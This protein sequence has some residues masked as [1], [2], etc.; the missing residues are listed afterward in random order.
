MT[1]LT[2]DE[3]NEIAVEGYV[4]FYPLVTMDVSRRIMTNVPAGMKPGLGPAG[5]FHHMRAYPDENFREVVRPT[6]ET[7]SERSHVMRV[8]LASTFLVMTVACGGSST[9]Q[10]PPPSGASGTGEVLG[11]PATGAGTTMADSGQI[12]PADPSK[13]NKTPGYSPYAG[14]NYPERAYFGDEHVHT[15]WSADAGGSGATLGPE[16]AVRFARGEEV[17]ATS[18]QP[19]KLGKP[20]DWVAITDHSDGMGVIAEVLKQQGRWT[21]GAL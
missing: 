20:L 1:S 6:F 5:V 16:E 10:S 3:A 13:F 7:L 15:A 2:R 8:T 19:V 4:Y 14:R 18:G 11:P 9:P 17:V 12:E 21:Y